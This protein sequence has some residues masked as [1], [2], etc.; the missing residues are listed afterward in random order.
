MPVCDANAASQPP[1]IVALRL[2][3]TTSLPVPVYV[4]MATLIASPSVEPG[5]PSAPL[6]LAQ[7]VAGAEQ[8]FASL[9]PTAVET[10][11]GPEARAARG[12][13]EREGRGERKKYDDNKKPM[14][15]ANSPSE[16]FPNKQKRQPQAF[17]YL[18]RPALRT[19]LRLLV[20]RS[21]YCPHGIQPKSRAS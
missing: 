15:H 8:L 10:Y 11:Q 20:T 13:I 3:F 19:F 5:L 16:C 4:P 1:E 12:G 17:Y 7:G 6:M 9:A 2:M 14:L 18:K 21:V